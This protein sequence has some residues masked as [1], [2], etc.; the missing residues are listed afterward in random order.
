[1]AGG[2]TSPRNGVR[3]DRKIHLEVIELCSIATESQPPVDCASAEVGPRL[4]PNG[5]KNVPKVVELG[6]PITVMEGEVALQETP[7][8]VPLK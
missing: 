7:T 4:L 3:A 8:D 1:M 2:S 6:E 5:D